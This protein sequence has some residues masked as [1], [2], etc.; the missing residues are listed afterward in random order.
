[1]KIEK[2]GSRIGNSTTGLTTLKKGNEWWE[3]IIFLVFFVVIG[4]CMLAIFFSD[5]LGCGI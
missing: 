4:F 5:F 1:M 3:T 2:P